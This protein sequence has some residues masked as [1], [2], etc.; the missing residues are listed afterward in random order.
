[1]SIA[2]LGVVLKAFGG[3]ELDPA[4]KNQLVKEALLMTLAHASS[5]DTNVMSVEVSTV[6]RAIRDATGEELSE[7]DFFDGVAKALNVRPHELAGLV[8]A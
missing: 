4:E 2:S 8:D 5:S 7:A 6:Q 3:N 1:M